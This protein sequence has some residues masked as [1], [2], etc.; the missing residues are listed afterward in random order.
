MDWNRS[1]FGLEQPKIKRGA[2]LDCDRSSPSLEQ[3][4]PKIR[5]GAPQDLDRGGKRLGLEQ[6]K[7]WTEADQ[8]WVRSGRRL[9]L[10]GAAKDCN[11][12]GPR[13]D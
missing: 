5:I 3:E 6:P 10:Y 8:D 4:Q 11:R 7:I 9:G 12:S 2:T 13:V 1:R